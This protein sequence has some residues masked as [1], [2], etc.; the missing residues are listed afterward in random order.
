MSECEMY[1]VT[2]PGGVSGREARMLL[3]GNCGYTTIDIGARYCPGCGAKIVSV[4]D[5][6][7]ECDA[8]KIARDEGFDEG[9]EAAREELDG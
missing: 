5:D 6:G 7:D 8:I 2:L 4:T 3:C 1:W 9:Y